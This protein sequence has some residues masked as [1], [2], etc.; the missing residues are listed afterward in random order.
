M[1]DFA[2]RFIFVLIL[3]GCAG[4]SSKPASVILPPSNVQHVTSDLAKT[5]LTLKDEIMA[6]DIS[7]DAKTGEIKYTLPDDALVRIRIG[8]KDGGP[9]LLTFLDWEPRPKGAHVEV[10]DKKD[11]SGQITIGERKD[12]LLIL[13]C[14][15]AG[16]AGMPKT[17][18]SLQKSPDFT[19]EFPTV[20]KNS[21]GQIVLNKISPVRVSLSEEDKKRLTES[22]YEIMFFI[23]YTFLFEDEDGV[24]P[25][26]Y[27]FNTQGINDG[28]H[29]LTVNIIGYQGD[30][31]TKS[32]KILIQK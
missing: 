5:S 15:P 13:T 23:D 12:L 26:T 10:W 20:Q 19:V 16:Q 31:G 29:V 27:Q 7:F 24:S 4:S 30:I 32:A 8:I 18:A 1:R 22:K 6:T 25:F 11:A 21:N 14:L 28:E 2:F 17:G 3:A 9:M